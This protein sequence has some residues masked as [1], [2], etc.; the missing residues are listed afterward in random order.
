MRRNHRRWCEA[1]K[2]YGFDYVDGVY[3]ANLKELQ[4]ATLNVHNLD[5][6]ISKALQFLEAQKSQGAGTTQAPF[7]STSPLHSTTGRHHGPIASHWNRIRVLL[8][9][10]LYLKDSMFYHHAQTFCGV[11]KT[12]VLRT[13]K[14]LHCGWMTA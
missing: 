6:T 13:T 3:A 7:F 4:N 10:G 14:R 2:P 9:K 11:I 12:P 8:E 1:I 5:W